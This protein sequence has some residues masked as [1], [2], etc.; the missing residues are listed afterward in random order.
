VI[1][2]PD[3]GDILSDAA[4]SVGAWIYLA[5]PALAFLETG[6]FVGVLVP[7]ETAIVIGGVGAQSGEVELP[8]LIALV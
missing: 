5:I 6:A 7:G 4:Y 3:L 8:L 1:E 2:T